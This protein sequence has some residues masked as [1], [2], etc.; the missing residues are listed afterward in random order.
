MSKHAPT[1]MPAPRNVRGSNNPAPDTAEAL[2]RLERAASMLCNHDHAPGFHRTAGDWDRLH[3]AI[4]DARAA[5]QVE[6][7]DS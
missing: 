1:P 7:G 2:R 6:G 5:V 4:E 3:A